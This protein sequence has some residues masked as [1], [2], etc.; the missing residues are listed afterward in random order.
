MSW[1]FYYKKNMENAEQI[2][3]G[4]VANPLEICYT[5]ASK[6]Q[7]PPAVVSI[8]LVVYH[9]LAFFSKGNADFGTLRFKTASRLPFTPR[10]KWEFCP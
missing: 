8:Y 6:P 4:G 10:S 2:H 3:A 1:P 7:G 5:D 9:I